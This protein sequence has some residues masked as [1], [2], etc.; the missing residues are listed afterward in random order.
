[1]R[2]GA[3]IAVRSGGHCFEDFVDHP[4]VTAVID[5]TLMREVSF[6]A[7]RGA[8]VVAAGPPSARCTGRSTSAGAS[9]FRPGTTRRW[10]RAGRCRAAVTGRC[11]AFSGS[12][13]TT[14]TRWRSS[15][16]T[17]RARSGPWWRAARRTTATP[18]C[19]PSSR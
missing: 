19:T 1:M 14:C 9:R 4:S 10:G 11:A 8:F 12:S 7:Q 6:D 15:S 16:W 2:N 17:G 13:A 5:M 3:R 18:R